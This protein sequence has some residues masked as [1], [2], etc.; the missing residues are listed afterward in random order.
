MHEITQ[1]SEVFQDVLAVMPER[2]LWSR[3]LSYQQMC[4][5]AVP[6]MHNPIATWNTAPSN[7][8]S[9]LQTCMF[10]LADLA[11]PHVTL[12]LFY[13]SNANCCAFKFCTLGDEVNN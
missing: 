2:F 11:T 10:G 12:V 6:S 8:S 9:P 5:P 3:Q 7:H 13:R 4:L 1:L